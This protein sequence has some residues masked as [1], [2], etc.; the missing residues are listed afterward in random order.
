MVETSADRV[1]WGVAI[2]CLVIVMGG[3]GLV[4]KLHAD[5]LELNEIAEV[6]IVN[7]QSEH[8]V[9]WKE[10]LKLGEKFGRRIEKRQVH[11]RRHADEPFR[12]IPRKRHLYSYPQ[13]MRYQEVPRYFEPLQQ[14]HLPQP[15]EPG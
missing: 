7:F 15:Q 1:A 3:A 8:E 5:L 12:S 2:G 13:P 11:S 6:E 14:V 4:A 10:A 9:I